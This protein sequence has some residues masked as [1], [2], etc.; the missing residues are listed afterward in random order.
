M[1]ITLVILILILIL[2]ILTL[3]L[4][5]KIVPQGEEW[6]IEYLGKFSRE[7]TPGLNLIW[8]YVEKVRAKIDTRDTLLEIPQQE[9][10][11]KDNAVLLVNAVAYI[12]VTNVINAVYGVGDYQRAIK[13]LVMTTLRS[14]IGNMSLDEALSHREEIKK[15][16][17]EQ[18]IED[19]ADWGVTVK[20]VEIQD[21]TPS[22]SMQ[23]SMEKQAAAE[24]EKRAKILNAEGD[25]ET[26][27]RHAEAELV[28]AEATAKSLKIISENMNNNESVLLLLGEK[29][30]T[31]VEKISQSENSKLIIYPADIQSSLQG[32]MGKFFNNLS[33][34]NKNP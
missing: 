7:L 3:Y 29:Y 9:V 18:I 24:R 23:E 27:K 22:K 32:I 11:T 34:T 33:S 16:L 4:G 30:I 12:R 6:V 20:L 28:M 19:I 8:P 15:T 10:I 21:I 26:A 17:K 25:L 1:E 2:F 31:S 14:L 13:N 5:I